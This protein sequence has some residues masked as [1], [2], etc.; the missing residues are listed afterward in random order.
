MGKKRNAF[1]V[2]GAVALVVAS[3]ATG[4][5]GREALPPEEVTLKV[6]SW[7]GSFNEYAADFMAEYPHIRLVRIAPYSETAGFGFDDAYM[8]KNVQ[9]M[10]AAQPDVALM[11]AQEYIRLSEE[12]KL[13]SLEAL[14]ER[15]EFDGASYSPYVLSLLRAQGGGELFGVSQEFFNEALF[16]NKTLFSEY[17]VTEPREGMSWAETLELAAS[18]PGNGEDG[19]AGYFAGV[20]KDI[21]PWWLLQDIG[22]A[23]GLEYADEERRKFIVATDGWANVWKKVSEGYA[24]GSILELAKEQPLNALGD[25]MPFPP[26]DAYGPFLSGRAAMMRQ[27]AAFVQFLKQ[28]ALPFEW[29][30]VSEPVDPDVGEGVSMQPGNPYGVFRTSAHPDEAWQ[31]ITFV[32]RQEMTGR[33]L[34]LGSLPARKDGPLSAEPA[35]APFYGPRPSPY[36]NYYQFNRKQPPSEVMARFIALANSR[37]ADVVAEKL[38]VEEALLRLEQEATAVWTA[39]PEPDGGAK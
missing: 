18:F 27:D 16:Y 39:T 24:S 26:E 4:C 8:T 10:D 29:G 19:I 31:Y 12:G 22:L 9:A 6:W 32:T 23:A 3:L 17:G 34:E 20:R 38:T 28:Q 2:L 21:S 35:Y 15:P 37:F 7:D 14:V 30:V 25:E 13:L 36:G 1:A 33:V 5:A 11:T